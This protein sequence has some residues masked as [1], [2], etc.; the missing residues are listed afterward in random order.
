M[1]PLWGYEF[2]IL[3]TWSQIQEPSRVP[4]PIISFTLVVVLCACVNPVVDD[5]HVVN[6]ISRMVFWFTEGSFYLVINITRSGRITNGMKNVLLVVDTKF[7]STWKSVFSFSWLG[8]DM[9]R[10][11]GGNISCWGF[12][13]FIRPDATIFTGIDR[14]C[15]S[16]KR[17]GFSASSHLEN[18]KQIQHP[19]TFVRLKTGSV[20]LI[21]R[22]TSSDHASVGPRDCTTDE[23]VEH[24]PISILADKLTK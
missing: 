17:L 14:L 24:I 2:E 21:F 10:V 9:S 23:H 1:V 20:V 5:A 22:S 16:L 13:I 6:V 15:H 7:N 11:I 19:P 3:F 12:S 8:G 18:L 4:Y